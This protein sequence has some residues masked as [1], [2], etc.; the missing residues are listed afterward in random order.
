[1]QSE[2]IIA[3]LYEKYLSDFKRKLSFYSEIK[4]IEKT[5]LKISSKENFYL[6]F[7]S[8]PVHSSLP[9][10]FPFLFSPFYSALFSLSQDYN[11][12][13]SSKK[14]RKIITSL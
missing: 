9:F 12:I 8:K 4:Y 7:Q 1:M 13:T 2:K 3:P 14:L 11:L 6:S 10:F 5:H